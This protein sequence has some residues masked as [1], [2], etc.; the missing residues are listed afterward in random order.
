MTNTL[1]TTPKSHR[2]SPSPSS[3]QLPFPLS[4]RSTTD[5]C[6]S[7]MPACSQSQYYFQGPSTPSLVNY[8]PEGLGLC[9]ADLTHQ[10]PAHLTLP[11]FSPEAPRIASALHE[12]CSHSLSQHPV[13][14]QQVTVRSTFPAH[15]Q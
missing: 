3:P 14:R 9:S 4:L 8:L 1:Q 13:L 10:I 12:G 5:T 7:Q 2:N 6:P 15:L 11:A